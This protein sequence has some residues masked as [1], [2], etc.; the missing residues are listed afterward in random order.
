MSELE[1]GE[2]ALGSSAT[3]VLAET[4]ANEAEVASRAKRSRATP[5]TT[6]VPLSV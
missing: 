6:E 1:H 4:K 5:E 3:R 2:W